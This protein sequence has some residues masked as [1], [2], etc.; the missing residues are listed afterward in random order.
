LLGLFLYN[1]ENQKEKEEKK[2]KGERM[3][4]RLLFAYNPSAGDVDSTPDN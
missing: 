3:R 2:K 1:K 4:G